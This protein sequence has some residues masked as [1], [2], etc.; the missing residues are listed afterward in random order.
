MLVILSA[1]VCVLGG[2]VE[3]GATAAAVNADDDANDDD[4][5]DN[6][7]G[8]KCS[9]SAAQLAIYAASCGRT[10]RNTRNAA[11]RFSCCL[12]SLGGAVP[13]SFSIERK[14]EKAISI[15][16]DWFLS[17]CFCFVFVVSVFLPP[18]SCD[19][20]STMRHEDGEGMSLCCD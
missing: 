7:D 15:E 20:R 2:K 11:P 9:I 8:C 16:I 4:A 5:N 3:K 14:K 12:W 10:R 17:F 13:V 18:F 6:D 19:I 1:H